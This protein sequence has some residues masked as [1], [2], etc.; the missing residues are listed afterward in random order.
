MSLKFSRD[1]RLTAKTQF[2]AVKKNGQ[3]A[4]AGAFLVSFLAAEKSR[5]GVIVSRAS[6]GSVDRNR[7]KRV[8]RELF[9]TNR[10]A[11]PKGDI[12]IVAG[13]KSGEL[14]NSKIRELVGLALAKLSK[15]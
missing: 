14:P 5:L 8:L 6:G 4:R 7:I 3:R 11:F 1:S 10:E 2:A 9:R 13:I 12:V 15:Q